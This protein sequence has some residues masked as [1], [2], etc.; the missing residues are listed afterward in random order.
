MGPGGRLKPG[1]VLPKVILYNKKWERRIPSGLPQEVIQLGKEQMESGKWIID[2][3]TPVMVDDTEV[4]N[5]ITAAAEAEEEMI[6][7]QE[8]PEEDD[9]D[10]EELGDAEDNDK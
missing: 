3:A 8:M 2:A 4:E 6:L 5:E 10:E 1:V 7:S 9:D